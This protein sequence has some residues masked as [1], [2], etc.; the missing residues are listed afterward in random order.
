MLRYNE[1]HL[2]ACPAHGRL[3][4]TACVDCFA[5]HFACKL[6]HDVLWK[7]ELEDRLEAQKEKARV[8][9]ERREQEL[10][11]LAKKRRDAVT[12]AKKAGNCWKC[13]GDGVLWCNV[14]SKSGYIYRRE[15]PHWC[16]ERVRVR[17]KNCNGSGI[18]GTC[19]ACEGSGQGCGRGQ[20]KKGR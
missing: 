3:R 2:A 14:C 18:F 16:R 8:A 5:A 19:H 15:G 12:E 13:L 1:L 11:E 9:A 4:R 10:Q 17:C 6:I 20:K 7:K